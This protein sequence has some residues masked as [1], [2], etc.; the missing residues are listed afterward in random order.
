MSR[1]IKTPNNKKRKNRIDISNYRDIVQW[2]ISK[3]RQNPRTSGYQR[4]CAST[5][6]LYAN[7]LG[8]EKVRAHFSS[9]SKKLGCDAS[10]VEL[11]FALQTF[12]TFLAQLTVFYRLN[13]I[14]PVNSLSIYEILNLLTNPDFYQKRWGVQSFLPELWSC[15]LFSICDDRE[16]NE[17][18]YPIV[19]LSA[20]L[21]TQFRGSTS[22]W[23]NLL[24]DLYEEIMPRQIRHDLGEYF[25]PYWLAEETIKM[26]GFKGDLNITLLDPGCGTGIFLLAAAEMKYQAN[27]NK[28]PEVLI[29]DIL[30]TVVGCDINPVCV[31]VARLNFVCWFA[32]KFGLP[33]HDIKIP[34]MHY[35]TVFERPAGNT[36]TND[37]GN[38]LPEGCDYLV[39]NPPWI[40]WNSLPNEYRRQVEQELLP[41]YV[42]FDFHGQEAQLGHSNDDYLVTFTLVTIHRYLK[43]GGLCS[44]I[45]K[46]PLL[47]NVSGKTFRRFCIRHVQGDVWLKVK[48]VADL[49]KVKPFG[50]GNETAI[51][52]LQRGKKTVYPVPYEIWSKKNNRIIIK[53]GEAKPLNDATSSWAVLTTDLE[54][55]E[56][57]VGRCPYEIRHGLKHDAADIIIVDPIERKEDKVLIRSKADGEEYEIEADTVY[58]FLQP[59]HIGAW[60]IKGYTYAII[61]QHKAGEDNENE[62][63]KTLPLTY[64]YL[65]RFKDRF[66]SRKSRIFGKKPFYTL[67]GLGKYTWKPFKVCW[68]GLG[69]KPEF[70]VVGSVN[71]RLIGKKLLIPDGTIY[72]IP[73][74]K[75]E[76][77]HFVCSLLNSETVCKFLSARS[78]KSKRG[79]SKKVMEQLALPLFDPE[80]SRH[81]ELVSWS[82]NMHQK[83]E[84]LYERDKIEHVVKEVLKEQR[85]C[86]Q[87]LF[88]FME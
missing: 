21:A 14:S 1:I 54:E 56:F 48:K 7:I 28:P 81:I 27:K 3:L 11:L 43:D 13:K 23:A 82:L 29:K 70:V 42:L 76:E 24:T 74:E 67:F 72:F 40:S 60:G 34:V 17:V 20:S 52:V 57:M 66:L 77:A 18:F 64:S 15:E 12:Y 65:T 53:E 86:Q 69:F 4:W 61:P 25:T 59:R 63:A 50:I 45:I 6:N 8:R 44:F 62:L 79:L 87:D 46:Q 41:R 36:K 10:P 88:S 55:T 47:T 58:P 78:G 22:S 5:S 75:K 30:R 38:I 31:L 71:D 83:L 80:D 33:L 32:F 35:D 2:L 51:I 19:R 9:L 85:K 49:R 16:V 39:G 37:I 84:M 26:S 73:F 68:C